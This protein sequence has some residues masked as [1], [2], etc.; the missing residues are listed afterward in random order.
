MTRVI[1]NIKGS[2]LGG[3]LEETHVGMGLTGLTALDLGSMQQD[4]ALRVVGAT[5]APAGISKLCP[6][7]WEETKGSSGRGRSCQVDQGLK[8]ISS[9]GRQDLL[10]PT[11]A[12]AIWVHLL[13]PCHLLVPK[14]F[15]EVLEFCP[16]VAAASALRLLA[17]ASHQLRLSLVF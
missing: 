13:T 8:F 17:P 4:R 11:R 6:M 9:S 10:P 5:K 15:L 7:A 1:Q 2:I 12:P 14:G 3:F 16:E